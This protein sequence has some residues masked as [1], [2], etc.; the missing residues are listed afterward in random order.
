MVGK[1]AWSQS[2][3]F[4]STHICMWE[5]DHKEGWVPKNW[6]SQTVVL[7]K[8]LESPLDSKE[9]K[10]VNPKGD[11]LWI[12]IGR[13]DAEAEVS[14]LW[15]PDVKR[16]LIG[17]DP[18]V[19]KDWRQEKRV[20]RMRW[21]DGITDLMDM[22]LSKLQEMVMDRKAWCAVVYGVTKSQ[23]RPSN[24]TATTPLSQS[25]HSWNITF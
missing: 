25:K 23:T 20:Q 5:L 21:S 18:D 2:Y 10:P 12:F 7:Q 6:C 3:G 24:W 13:T 16:W 9:I 8:T 14:I 15:P 4:S 11:Q 19:G 17:K 22:S 1:G